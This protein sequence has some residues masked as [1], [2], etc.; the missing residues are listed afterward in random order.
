MKPTQAEHAIPLAPAAAD[1][2]AHGFVRTKILGAVDIQQ[3]REFRSGAVDAALDG[4]DRA[5]ADRRGVL[6][7]EAGGTDQDQRFALVLRK[8]VERGAELLEL[9]MRVL[10]RL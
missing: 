5:A 9:Q 3:C 7:G 10:R 6:I 4:A 1:D 8:L 2:G